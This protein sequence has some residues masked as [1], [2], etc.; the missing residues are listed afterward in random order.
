MLVS[1]IF[2]T[3]LSFLFAQQPN[4]GL[5][6]KG[7][8][9]VSDG[10]TLFTP[11]KN[12]K[13][14][15]IDNCGELVNEWNFGEYPALVCYLLENGNLLR[16]GR[17][18]IEIKDW[19]DNRVW[20]YALNAKLGINQH[21]DIEPLPNGNVL[22]LITDF[23]SS[24]DMYALGKDTAAVP[25]DIKLD[26]I[27]ELKPI[28]LDSAE[29]VWEWRFTDHFI[30]DL[31]NTR[32]NFGVV[33]DHPELLDINYPTIFGTD[34][35]HCNGIDYNPSLD[36]IVISA[37][38]L[39]EIYIIDHSTST[40][41]AASHSGGNSNKGGDFLFR[42]GN[43]LVY[44]QGTSADQ[45]LFIQHDPKWVP[46]GYVDEG[47]LSIYSN[48]GDSE[49]TSYSSLVIIETPMVNGAYPI[50]GGKFLPLDYDWTWHGEILGDTMREGKKSSLHALPNGNVLTCETSKGR[51]TEI[52]KAGEVVWV[53]RNPRGEITYLQG[54]SVI[55][56]NNSLFRG[57]KYPVDYIAF[58]GKDLTGKGILEGTN[59]ISDTCELFTGIKD[60]PSLDILIENPVVNQGLQFSSYL[61]NSSL[62]IYDLNGK[63]ALFEEQF[64]GKYY[65]VDLNAGV[66]F[67]EIKNSEGV[68][69][70]KFILR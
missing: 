68:F 54:D 45:Q 27:I 61:S 56:T 14:F 34:Y 19:D 44:Q 65:V 31:D 35:T 50:S 4:L 52:T 69:Q 64:E 10:Y 55:N 43:P 12:N 57:E 40:A 47:K 46:E 16:A 6:Y 1:I 3:P 36:Q 26:K 17:D 70:T 51:L 9:H 29:I 49:G 33:A 48:G 25:G 60:V 62:R 5:L 42:W 63:L 38:S 11:E 7:S 37:R 21:H 32:A 41:E 28:G 67:L 2:L 8:D 59:A 53:Y 66:Y 22:C 13:V 18:T 23:V 24:E 15:L 30:Q 58:Q 20:A 39:D